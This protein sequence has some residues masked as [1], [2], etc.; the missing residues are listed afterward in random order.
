[1]PRLPALPALAAALAVSLA[2]PAMAH[3]LAGGGLA[4]GLAHPLLGIDHLL[5]MLAVGLWAWQGGRVTRWTLPIA[6]PLA[7][8]A[9]AGLGLAGLALPAIE[10]GVAASVLVLGLL[11]L[12]AVRA[13]L[14]PSLALV[15]GFA[16]LHGHA[17]AAELPVSA[18]PALYAAG[19]L[20]TTALLH[21]AGLGLGQGLEAPRLAWGLRAGGAAIAIAGVVLL[22]T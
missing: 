9:G 4:A 20:A 19:F 1:M 22:A 13:P 18:S 21:V 5:A 16:I 17:H 12:L 2:G 14:A 6:F 15:A 7:M 11:I 10:A 3:P 8:A